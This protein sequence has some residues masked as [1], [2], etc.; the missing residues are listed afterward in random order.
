MN[1]LEWNNSFV[2]EFSTGIGEV[3]NE[4]GA[5]FL[6]GDLG[7][8]ENW[9]YTTTVTGRSNRVLTRKGTKPGET[10][11]MTGTAGA[12][13]TEAAIS[14]FNLEN[15]FPPIE[16]NLRKK[17]S[18]LISRFATTCIDTSDGV[19]NSLNIISE[20]NKTGY[21][22]IACRYHPLSKQITAHLD[23]PDELLLLGECGEYELLFTIDNN[24]LPDFYAE[25]EK[26]QLQF[27]AIGKITTSDIKILHTSNGLITL[28]D[29]NI[30]GRDFKNEKDYVTSLIKYLKSHGIN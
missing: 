7:L 12:G 23:V 11:V 21:E 30:R 20:I 1:S 19:V 22:F 2:N 8:S 27:T 24:K 10:I 25:A 3:L 28:S 4:A 18:E 16:F 29:F 17:E 6:G 26:M 14:L 9:H 15:H 13:N 5:F